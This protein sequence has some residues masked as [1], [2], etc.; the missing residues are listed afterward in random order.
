MLGETH[1]DLRNSNMVLFLMVYLGLFLKIHLI[2]YTNQPL[3]LA[4]WFEV[5]FGRVER[6]Y[7]Q[8][9]CRAGFRLG[10]LL[11]SSCSLW[12]SVKCP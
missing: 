11:L 12:E 2:S 4:C 1:T 10:S 5:L 9:L 7:V 3:V 8:S 6:G